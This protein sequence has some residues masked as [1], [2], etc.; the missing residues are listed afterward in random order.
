[1]LAQRVTTTGRPW[2]RWLARTSRS[3]PALLAEYAELGSSGADS[4][5]RPVLMEPYTS[6]VPTCRKRAVPDGGVEQHLRADDV[7]AGDV[8]TGGDRAVH[9]ALRGH[10]GDRV[11][12]G[13]H[14]VNQ[15]GVAD[16]PDDEPQ[17]WV[18]G[19]VRAVP[20]VREAVEDGDPGAREGG[21]AVG[22]HGPYEVGADEARAAG[23]Q[24]IHRFR[25]VSAAHTQRGSDDRSEKG[26]SVRILCRCD[27]R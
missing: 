1:M 23:Y 11:V 17:P 10:V 13:Q 6:S 4:S 15:G 24:K 8:G 20:G 25:S 26:I 14:G 19:Q 21:V 18:V 16:V 12:A 27:C 7:G 22:E 2:V 9:V 5:Q 3:A